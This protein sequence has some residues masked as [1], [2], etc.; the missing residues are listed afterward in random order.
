MSS[1]FALVGETRSERPKAR[2]PHAGG[3]TV[4]LLAI[5]TWSTAAWGK[6]ATPDLSKAEQEVR[7]ALVLPD[8]S[9][10]ALVQQL[11]QSKP[12]SG[13]EALFRF[14][15]FSR[16]GMETEAI[17][18]LRDLKG[19][20]PEFGRSLV[21]YG[22]SELTGMYYEACNKQRDWNLAQ[23]IVDIFADNIIDVELESGLVKH[24]LD[25]GWSVEQIDEW[26]A[27][28]P[29]GSGNFWINERLTF[30]KQRGR[31]AAFEKEL[32][33]RVRAKPDDAAE[34]LAFLNALLYARTAPKSLDLAWMAKIVKPNRA[35]DAQ[36]IA[37]RLAELGAP[38]SAAVFYRQ[39][40][41]IPLTD[42]DIQEMTRMCQ[43]YQEYSVVRT[44]FAIAVREAL[45]A[46]LLKMDQADEAQKWM[47]AAAE[48]REK[49]KLA[50]NALLAGQVQA[51][52]GRRDIE[53]QIE[54]EEKLSEDDP[55]YWQNRALYYAGRS[56]P[57][58]E[59]EA[60]KKGLALT[61]PMPAPEHA[62]KGDSDPRSSLLSSYMRFLQRE[63]RE[64]EA[65]ALLWK[66]L[67][68]APANAASSITAR[69]L[70]TWQFEKH[71]SV[72]DAVLWK[73]LDSHVQWDPLEKILLQRMLE[74]QRANPNQRD[75]LFAR[76]EKLALVGGASRARVLGELESGMGFPQRAAPL[77]LHAAEQARKELPKEEQNE[78]A[79]SDQLKSSMEKGDWKNAE[80]LSPN[81]SAWQYTRIAVLA[82]RAGAKDDAMRLW[83]KAAN[84]DLRVTAIPDDRGVDPLKQMV[85]AGMRIELI[86]FYRDLQT[87]IPSS[88]I[89]PRVLDRL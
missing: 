47:L 37:S 56:E 74:S 2:G 50:R 8:A 13:Q 29:R 4:L 49:N 43:V 12:T 65:V 33:D 62:S 80:R 6:E 67:A 38:G 66:E 35:S 57:A 45:A 71:V 21:G 42:D 19:F 78:R 23:A 52:S 41:D 27:A 15:A 39:A 26:L 72:D 7:A 73:W 36:A 10:A 82:A 31:S 16:A 20:C 87:S 24:L 79:L 77:L 30:N 18:S 63:K 64:R 81:P 5:L 58:K 34:A 83:R 89:P 60:L 22:G 86:E 85:D 75:E 53:Q 28:K 40:M 9:L 11:G 17:Q 14:S 76:A 88:K 51:Q 55:E 44:D 32:A 84:L 59:E 54:S 68:D 25:S 70:L 46:C 3:A 69:W 1:R 61:K 48:I